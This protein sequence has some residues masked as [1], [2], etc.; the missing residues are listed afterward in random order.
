MEN[1][2]REELKNRMKALT[3]E[4]QRAVVECM[5]SKV[6]L[7]EIQRRLDAHADM[8][9]KLAEVLADGCSKE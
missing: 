4:E 5:P 6:M 3:G 1:M 2:E 8:L 9:L 7:Q